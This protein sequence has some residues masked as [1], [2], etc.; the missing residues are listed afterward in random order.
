[1]KQ[2]VTFRL[3]VNGDQREQ[4]K[5]L[6]G[7]CNISTTSHLGTTENLSAELYLIR[8]MKKA[9]A[10]KLFF[11]YEQINISYDFPADIKPDVVEVN[12][13]D[14]IPVKLVGYEG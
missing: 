12:E 11:R 3:V 9:D 7:S 10:T 14:L 13:Q 8:Y 6:K 2:L 4:Y 1:M 5:P